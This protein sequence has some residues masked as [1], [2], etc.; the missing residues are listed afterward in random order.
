MTYLEQIDEFRDRRWA[1]V[2]LLVLLALLG[3]GIGTIT[4]GPGDFDGP[5]IV[6]STPTPTP[7]PTDTPTPED[8]G[9][10]GTPTSDV[11][12]GPD[13]APS[14]T[15]TPTSRPENGDGETPTPTSQAVDV[16]GETA[17]PT[18]SQT[19]TEN[20]GSAG[21]GGG[22]SSTTDDGRSS[23]PGDGETPTPTDAP[24]AGD[25]EGDGGVDLETNRSEAILEFD[26]VLPGDAGREAVRLRNTGNVTA[27]FGVGDIN[28]TDHENGITEPESTVDT[29]GNGGELSAHVLV[30]IEVH[31]PNRSN[32][33]LYGTGSGAK[34]L[35]ALADK[36]PEGA[37]ELAPGENA[38]VAFDWH[39]PVETGNVV[40]SDGTTFTVDFG[41]AGPASDE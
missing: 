18:P 28:V 41:L 12:S 14:P 7:T 29:T 30:V 26:G 32:E 3:L 16:Q 1:L 40:Q 11:T 21:T 8:G 23:T 37:S 27:Q 24:D 6:V 19:E 25:E 31:Y 38:T 4:G 17:T 22:G 39:L 15:P 13:T 10:D 34:S 2:A 5:G 35:R 20:G 36:E 9:G 33:Y